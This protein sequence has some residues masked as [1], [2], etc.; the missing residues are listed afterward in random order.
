VQQDSTTGV[1]DSEK[2]G[3]LLLVTASKK[4]MRHAL[5]AED[6]SLLRIGVPFF[7]SKLPGLILLATGLGPINSALALG[8]FL[9]KG[10]HIQGVIN[11]GLA[12]S[13][14]LE[15][16]GICQPAL[17]CTEICPEFGLRYKDHVDPRG[18]KWGQGKLGSRVVWERLELEPELQATNMGIQLPGDW[19]LASSLTVF[20]VTADREL[21]QELQQRHQAQLENMEGFA[22][23]WA[24]LSSRVPFLQAR[25]V[26]NLVGSR[27]KQ[28]WDMQSS[29]QA[30][31]E[32]LKSLLPSRC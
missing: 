4:E 16:M 9:A 5:P 20:G 15:R 29:L 25:V 14:D 3:Q 6:L 32:I 1:F 13:F 22:L 28:Y 19:P 10:L 30:L 17:I 24:C 26:S 8:R 31:A 12:G 2:A 23:A 18:L 21:A 27:E 11:L 7:P